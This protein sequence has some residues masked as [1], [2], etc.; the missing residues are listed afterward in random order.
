MQS[1]E[2]AETVGLGY[3]RDG[4]PAAQMGCIGQAVR[5]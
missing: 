5:T 2:Q 1:P 3:E 4:N